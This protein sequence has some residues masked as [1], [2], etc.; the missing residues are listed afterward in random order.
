MSIFGQ[1]MFTIDPNATPEQ[2]ARKREM[3]AMMMPRFG[4]ARYV[5][6]G[7]GQA[8]TGFAIGRMNR[9]MDKTETNARQAA[10]DRFNAA[11][12]GRAQP[13]GFTVLGPTPVDPVDP[14]SPQGIAGDTMKA[15]GKTPDFGAL[16]AKY[17]LPAGYLERTAMIESGGDPN[18][19]N[20][21]SSAGGMFQ[22][23]DST[24]K[25]YGL[26]DKT[27]PFAS[28]DAAARFAADNRAYLA[29]ALGREPTAGELYLAHQQGA[30]GAAKLLAAGN[31][32]A[33]SVVGADAAG[34]NGGAGMT[35]ADFAGKWTGKFGET[36]QPAGL[37][38]GSLYALAADP[39]LGP[40]QKAAVAALIEQ[41][42]QAMDPLRNLEIQQRQLEIEALRNPQ[43]NR[44]TQFV[45]GVGLIDMN[46][47]EVI[48]DYGGADAVGVGADEYGLNPIFGKDANGNT[49]VLQLGKNGKAVQTVLPEGVTPDLGVKAYEGAFGS[50]TGEAAGKAAA[51]AESDIQAGQNALDLIDSIRNDPAR[52][53]A[54]GKSAFVGGIPGTGAYDFRL[55]VEQA[56]SGA[57][58]TAINQLRGMGALSNAEGATATAAVTRMN[59]A[60]SE[61]GFL[62]ALADY[63]KVVRQGMDKAASR[64]GGQ[65]PKQPQEIGGY[66]IEEAE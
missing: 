7:I 48:N 43:Q 32:P 34:L 57:F 37:D 36:V 31:A 6:E 40:E 25:Q 16:E 19:Q 3:L 26:T 47:G 58:M 53:M 54:T 12:T 24:A 44:E 55:K 33:A 41:Q 39:W 50:A 63:E 22:F 4:S 9:N 35:A 2:L 23:I 61:E 28:A 42:T 49:I 27:D 66:T 29:K 46:T 1:G 64:I 65:S 20:P 51:S 45:K 15:L 21:N 17:G 18:A 59:V 38:L 10:T 5:G 13:G 11:F 8:A 14:N 52:G 30:G 60:M 62:E 56:K